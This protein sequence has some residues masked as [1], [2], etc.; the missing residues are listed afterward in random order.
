[1]VF[2]DCHWS[3]ERELGTMVQE[4]GRRLH[5]SRELVKA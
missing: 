5:E 4:R 2:R 3:R 1:M